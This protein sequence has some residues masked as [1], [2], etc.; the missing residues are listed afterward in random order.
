M[1]IQILITTVIFKI[2]IS[3]KT[4]YKNK[5]MPKIFKKS[6]KR[7]DKREDWIT[8]ELLQL[9]NTT[10]DIYVDWEKNS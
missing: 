1:N 5:H 7:K 10:K 2:N 9:V 3:T 6:N 8:D 4:K